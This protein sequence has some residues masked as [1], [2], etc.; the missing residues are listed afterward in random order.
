MIGTLAV[1][2][3]ALAGVQANQGGIGN[4]NAGQQNGQLTI[5]EQ[6][7]Q[8]FPGGQLLSNGNHLR[9][10]WGRQFSR[11]ATPHDSVESFMKKWSTLWGVPFSQLQAVGP[12]QDGAHMIEL[13]NDGSGGSDFTAVYWSQQVRGV[14]VFRSH[15]W[16]LVGNESDFP[17]VL[18]GGT[19]KNLGGFPATMAN[20]DLNPSTLDP[21]VY[22]GEAVSVF[23]Q[24]P[25]IT[26]PRYVVWAG[27]DTQ[28][29]EPKLAVEFIA[30]V[31][32]GQGDPMSYE[33]MQFVVDADTGAVLYQ[34][35]MIYHGTA[36]AQ[37]NAIGTPGSKA[38]ACTTA[39]TLVMP[40]AKATIG[41][42]T[43]YADATG[44]LVYTYS[45]TA[46]QTIAPAMGG[47]YFNVVDNK[48]ALLTVASQSVADG[49]TGTFSF[50][51]AANQYYLSEVNTYIAANGARDLVLAA[52]PSYPTIATQTGMTIN[53]GVTGSCNAFYNGSSINFYSSGGGCNNTGY[54][55]V[56]WHEYGH[57]VVS[58]GGSGQSGYGEGMG[59]CIS[60]L[61]SGESVLGYGFQSCSTGIRNAANSC[62][63]SSSSA[64]NCGS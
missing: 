29:V 23:N 34:E 22:A 58:T 24:P 15:V 64:S 31:G 43:Y 62:V 56:A 40:Y 18:A 35:S 17:M 32:E 30:T 7:E 47:R 9:R 14:P 6:F 37:I 50:N 12:F 45:G 20:R 42:A 4:A 5:R 49:T 44:K 55:S 21:S 3:T 11:G 57:H 1:A 41:G 63:A 59:D 46:A 48:T 60:V 13:M 16:G 28:D 26:S 2:A 33:K 27:V 52:A 10:V 51:T 19:L 39:T 54:S 38:A 53:N 8:A 36:T 61:M 25:V